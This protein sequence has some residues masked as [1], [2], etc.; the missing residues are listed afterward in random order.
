MIFVPQ[1][2]QNVREYLLISLLED[3]LIMNTFLILI[4]TGILYLLAQQ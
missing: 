1:L 3:T 4:A 2:K